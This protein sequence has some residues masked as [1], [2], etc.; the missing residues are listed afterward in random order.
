M[1]SLFNTLPAL[2][3]RLPDVPEV[4][5]AVVFAAWRRTA[6]E[7]LRERAKP[8]SIE[9]R[10]LRVAV[11]D[12]NWQR[13]LES[14]APQ[15]LFKLNTLL[16]DSVVDYIE[17]VIDPAAFEPRDKAATT[18]PAGPNTPPRSTPR[19]RRFAI[20]HFGKPSSPPLPRASLTETDMDVRKIAKLAHLEI[21]DEE[22]DVYAPQLE[23]IVG[24]VKQLNELDTD[25]VEPMLG[26]LTDEGENTMTIR[27]DE[28]IP[29]LGQEAA[30]EEAPSAVAGHFQVP[31]VL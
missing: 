18:E 3:K 24:Y 10:R 30:L 15:L 12:K 7:E 17:F 1:E 19:H 27:E 14:L 4:R 11:P 8:L 25:S 21:T 13:Q 26:G 29:S 20:R 9:S 6:G 5:R 31:K 23:K 16:E 2:L 22:A 28:V